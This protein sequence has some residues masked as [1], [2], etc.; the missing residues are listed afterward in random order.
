M[1]HEEAFMRAIREAPEDDAPRLIFADWLEEHGQVDR[2]EFIRVQCRYE[3][4]PKTNLERSALMARADSLLQRNW[5]DWVGPLRDIVG[6]WYDRYGAGWMQEQYHP[7]S[8]K[9]FQRG[10]VDS[11][12]LKAESF[13]SRARELQRLTVLSE[14]WL[15]GAGNCS[16][17]LAREPTLSG[18]FILG[19]NDYYDAPLS[20]HNMVE[21]AASPYLRGLGALLVGR[22]NLG[23]DG[24]EALGQAPWMVSVYVLD[25]TDNGLSDRG[26]RALADSPYLVKLVSLCLRG[27][28]LS[29]AG[30][31]AL[32]DSPNLQH[33]VQLEYD[34][35][36]EDTFTEE[37]PYP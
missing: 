9:K 13:L 3:R 30:I 17:A 37:S 7:D 22:N 8:L 29:R 33:T 1:T 34:P 19:F 15:W 32:R 18:L 16:A 14:L 2:A 20:A 11:L 36:P 28:A 25:L 24:A 6:P 4:L 21:L 12:S 5:Q 27:N 10:F 35:P 23:D 26:V 31:A